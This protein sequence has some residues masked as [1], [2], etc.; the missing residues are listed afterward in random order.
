MDNSSI[1]LNIKHYRT[2]RNMSQKD[3][4]E[5][6]GLNLK[7]Y[8]RYETGETPILKDEVIWL[9][10][11][12]FKVS[13]E[14]LLL[15]YKPSRDAAQ[16]VRECQAEYSRSLTREKEIFEETAAQKDR[17]ISLLEDNIRDLRATVKR[18]EEIL[19]MY[20]KRLDESFGR[21]GKTAEND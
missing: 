3:V 16:E 2:L 19:K 13:P 7:T 20:E 5:R 6:T 18:Y 10:A 21:E 15:G 1:L 9:L 14:E 4:C 8:Q 11:E 17:Q 12:V